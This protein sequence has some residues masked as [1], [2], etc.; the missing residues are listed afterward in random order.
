MKYIQIYESA[1]QEKDKIKEKEKEVSSLK[2]SLKKTIKPLVIT[3][4][5]LVG[6]YLYYQKMMD[7]ANAKVSNIADSIIDPKI[8]L[9]EYDNKDAETCMKYMDELRNDIIK[10]K[11]IVY[12]DIQIRNMI[13]ETITHKL[14]NPNIL[15]ISIIEPE[16]SEK[17]MAFFSTET[18]QTKT[19]GAQIKYDLWSSS[20][21]VEIEVKSHNDLSKVFYNDKKYKAWSNAVESLIVHEFTHY[22]QII[23]GNKKD[24]YN[25]GMFGT[26]GKSQD[27][28][29]GGY[30]SN[31]GEL[32]AHAAQAAHGLK[33]QGYSKSSFLKDLKNGKKFK[34]F[35]MNNYQG[36]FKPG[37]L[38]FK[39]FMDQVTKLLPD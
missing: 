31:K 22:N 25:L 23:S 19:A 13:S 4:G 2:N 7:I 33:K 14:N 18:R 30:Y 12:S 6:L 34:N 9:N 24:L 8:V 27:E 39:V 37:S 16:L 15:K 29:T 36:I 20:K 35:A 1:K 10:N 26:I 17:I 32:E 28:I 21:E 38:V 11:N 3:T 5:V